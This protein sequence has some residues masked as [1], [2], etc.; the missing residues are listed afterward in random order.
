[1][2]D[3]SASQR[4]ITD[5]PWLAAPTRCPCDWDFVEWLE[6]RPRVRSIEYGR[7]VFH[8]GTGMHHYVG[9]MVSAAR[10]PYRVIGLTASPEEH[11]EYARLMVENPLALHRYQVLF[12]DI[13]VFDPSRWVP[14]LDEVTL[15]H[16]CEFTD[17]RRRAYG[18]WDDEAVLMRFL[19][20]MEPGGHVFFYT[21]SVGYERA[22][23]LIAGAIQRGIIDEGTIFKSLR[24]CTLMLQ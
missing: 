23:P 18:G 21:G 10:M 14:M 7:T 2:P 16:L 20:R 12:G 19:E 4:L 11:A 24:V 5:T 6:T 22:E 8:M 9:Q 3:T 13:Y 17:E 1:M 15:F